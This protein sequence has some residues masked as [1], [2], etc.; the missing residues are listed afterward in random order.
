MGAKTSKA[1][2]DFLR[3]HRKRLGLSLREVQERSATIGTPIP[4]PTLAKIEGGKVD[5]G[6]KRLHQLLKLYGLPMQAIGDLLDLEDLAGVWPT[7]QDPQVL[8]DH[9]VEHWK[10]GDVRKGLAHLLALREL[11]APGPEIA[12]VRQKGLLSFA[13]LAGSL[14][15][16]HL[17][18]QI[19]ENL[20]IESPE[21]DLFVPVFVQAAVTWN[22]LGS[23]EVAL[24]FLHRAE[25]HVEPGNQRQLAWVLHEKAVA[26]EQLQSFDLA[27]ES[28]DRAI[29]SYEAAGDDYGASTALGVR[30]RLYR[31]A[32]DLGRALE[33][34]RAGR[35]HAALHGFDRIRILRSLLEGFVMTE[36]GDMSGLPVLNEGLAAA[37]STSDHAA[38]FYAHYYL[39]KVHD[40]LGDSDRSDLELEAARYF[41]RFVDES[42]EEVTEIRNG[43]SHKEGHQ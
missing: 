10:R 27:H 32:G 18:R 8:Y 38:Q 3:H 33:A 22:G 7:E 30:A 16:Y 6:L 23:P 29:S 5:P 11:P 21:R 31:S 39:W 26:L 34:A 15:K 35:E 42:S 14:G 9:G 2:A 37:V 19:V 13:I 20:L 28:L 4:F 41:V 12:A 17:S 36:T 1:V 43:L 25:A 40:G 24:A